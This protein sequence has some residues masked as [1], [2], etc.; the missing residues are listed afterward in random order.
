MAPQPCPQHR[1]EATQMLKT[2]GLEQIQAQGLEALTFD[3]LRRKI[4]NEPFLVSKN[5]APKPRQPKA[6][7]PPSQTSP[8]LV[9]TTLPPK[10]SHSL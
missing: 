7:S 8:V 10:E 3:L 9:P 4:F 1:F 2:I 6:V 5:K